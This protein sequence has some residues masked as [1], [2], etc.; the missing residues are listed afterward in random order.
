[1]RKFIG[2]TNNWDL[3]GTEFTAK[4]PPEG[5]RMLI[6]S[7]KK[8]AY[9][10]RPRLMYFLIPLIALFCLAFFAL[11]IHFWQRGRRLQGPM[12]ADEENNLPVKARKSDEYVRLTYVYVAAWVISK[13][14]RVSEKKTAYVHG[15]FAEK[16]AGSET[17][18]IGELTKAL[19]NSTNIRNVAAW[20]LRHMRTN[21]ERGELISFLIDLSFADGDI[22]DR[23]FVAI[24]RF[25]DLTGVSTRFVADEIHQRRRAIYENY[26]GDSGLDLVANGTFFR[27]RA[28][29]L[30]ELPESA[31]KED[32]RKAY[33]K[34]ASRLHPDKFEAESE[35]VRQKAA[36]RFIE[37]K[38]AYQFLRS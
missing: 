37:I 34:M 21:K 26:S 36:E 27:R 13:N 29:F 32:I 30:L 8:F 3:K 15:Y 33:R 11:S 19:R 4:D 9:H 31:T 1:M 35:E 17:D 24:A 18:T 25:A 20:I 38:E 10:C 28:L 2:L 14:S 7:E 16:F 22:I 5:A 12:N 6:T 23:E